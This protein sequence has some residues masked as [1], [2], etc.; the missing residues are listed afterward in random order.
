MISNSKHEI[1]L[2]IP[3][4]YGY[5]ASNIGNIYSSW[6]VGANKS[7]ID[8]NQRKLIKPMTSG[9]YRYA[10]IR[11]NKNEYRMT[12]VHRLVCLAFYGVPGEKITASHINGI[13]TD[14]RA[15]NLMWETYADNLKRK[16]VH[17]T[18][19]RGHRNSRAKLSL[20]KIIEVK[21]HLSDGKILQKEIAKMYNVTE[22]L[23][24]LIKTGKRYRYD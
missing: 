4:F 7:A 16:V 2:P 20:D 17:G 18:D 11:V 9:G 24:S 15:D 5:Y 19:D 6:K 13:S 8:N 10:H 22:A 12:G 14:N 21:A 3:G 1:I 23:I